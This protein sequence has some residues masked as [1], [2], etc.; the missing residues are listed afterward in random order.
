MGNTEKIKCPRLCT[1][2][3]ALIS[4]MLT[5]CREAQADQTMPI[6]AR[7]HSVGI[8]LSQVS[9]HSVIAC[10]VKD[11]RGHAVPSQKVSVQKAAAV[12]GPFADWMSKKTNMKGQAL[13]PYAPP[14]YT[15]YVRCAAAGG[16]SPTQWIRGR[17][18]TPKPTSLRHQLQSQQ[19]LRH[20][21]RDPGRRSLRAQL[22][23]QQPLRRPPQQLLRLQ[24]QLRL[25]RLRP[26]RVQ[27]Q[28]SRRIAYR[29][30]YKRAITPKP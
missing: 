28:L 27:L 29:A 21:R 2:A 24:V 12:T 8:E 18:P 4:C 7:C 19:L 6:S 26:R 10:T 25:P 15:W 30:A 23:G 22:R 1:F 14:T 5:R 16:V 20:Q 9:G 3:V 13:F 17:R 11:S